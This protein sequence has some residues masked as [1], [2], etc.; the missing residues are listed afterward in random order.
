MS[1]KVRDLLRERLEDFNI[2]IGELAIS[3]LR[4]GPQFAKAVEDKQIA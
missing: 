2:E 1:A 4:F 3:E